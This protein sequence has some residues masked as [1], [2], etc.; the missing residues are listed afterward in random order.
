MASV[1]YDIPLDLELLRVGLHMDETHGIARYR[2]SGWDGD[3]FCLVPDSQD[4]TRTNLN[5]AILDTL[6]L[7]C[8]HYGDPAA[9][10]DELFCITGAF[11]AGDEGFLRK[12]GIAS[13]E[14]VT[15]YELNASSPL[16]EQQRRN[17]QMAFDS[18]EPDMCLGAAQAFASRDLDSWGA[19]EVCS[20]LMDCLPAKFV[21]PILEGGRDH[22]QLRELHRIADV[23]HEAERQGDAFPAGLYD[24]IAARRDLPAGQ[25]R[26]LRRLLVAA[27]R[28]FDPTWLRL[29][30][31]QLDSVAYALKQDVPA[32]IVRIYSSG[33]AFSA[34]AMDCL[35]D[36]WLAGLRGSE[37]ARLANPRYSPAQL[38]EAE[39]ACLAHVG[40][41]ISAEQLDVICNPA[42][43][44]PVMNALRLGFA[45]YGLSAEEARDF[46]APGV[47]SEQVWYLIERAPEPNEADERASD[48]AQTETQRD[49]GSLRC[50]AECS[51][52]ASDQLS[53]SQR[54]GQASERE[55]LE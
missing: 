48:E 15:A 8:G 12:G 3:F 32:G 14:K 27:G 16:S 41:D 26:A 25:L 1:P 45:H 54:T 31:P 34:T 38:W 39:A 53:Q 50:E 46:L 22:A 28:N 23:L 21:A 36:A 35:T 9:H 33:A 55:V 44:Q 6:R 10:S 52:A 40:G 47:T 19:F 5:T 2:L 42:L 20:A 51:H 37:F 49:E 18:L 29:N 11:P 17:V 24:E 4:M 7:L 30:R 43:P 13:V